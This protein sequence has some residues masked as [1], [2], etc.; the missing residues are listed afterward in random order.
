MPK[1]ATIK[2]RRDFRYH[3]FRGNALFSNLATNNSSLTTARQNTNE[4]LGL[5]YR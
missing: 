2:K 3:G 4:N 1:V 5:S